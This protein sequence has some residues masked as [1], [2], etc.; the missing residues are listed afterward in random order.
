[1]GAPRRKPVAPAGCVLREQAR[2]VVDQLESVPAGP[3]DPECLTACRTAAAAAGPAEKAAFLWRTIAGEAELGSVAQPVRYARQQSAPE[4][5]ERDGNVADALARVAG[6]V[7]G[8]VINGKAGPVKLLLL[9]GESGKTA[10]Q[11]QGK[12]RAD[13]KNRRSREGHSEKKRHKTPVASVRHPVPTTELFYGVG[14]V[15]W[16]GVTRQTGFN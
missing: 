1:M 11:H 3:A 13:P 7:R 14:A 8:V 5:L 9:L 10:L 15:E 6:Q 2:R 4:T 16:E 12:R